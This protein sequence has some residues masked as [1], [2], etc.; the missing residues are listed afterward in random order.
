MPVT[1][2]PG[3]RK[4]RPLAGSRAR[5]G[6]YARAASIAALKL[7]PELRDVAMSTQLG[8]RHD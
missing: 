7:M 2:L 5:L 8:R 3:A 1:S 4:R 6:P